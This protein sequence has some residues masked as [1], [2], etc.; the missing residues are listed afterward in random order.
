MIQSEFRGAQCTTTGYTQDVSRTA[1]ARYPSNL[2][3]SATAPLTIVAAVAANCKG[4][5]TGSRSPSCRTQTRHRES[6]EVEDDDAR[7]SY[8]ARLQ[9]LHLCKVRLSL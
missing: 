1:Y 5:H 7:R 6:A 4:A 3:R 8:I 2:H 9:S